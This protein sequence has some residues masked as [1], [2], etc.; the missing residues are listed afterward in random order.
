MD[1]LSSDE[2][3]VSYLFF[4]EIIHGNLLLLNGRCHGI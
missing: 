3:G 2:D 1:I 4:R